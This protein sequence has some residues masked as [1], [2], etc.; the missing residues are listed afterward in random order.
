[1]H[2]I[3][4]FLVLIAAH[5]LCDYP[6]QGNFMSQFKHPDN[7]VIAGEKVWPWILGGH[8]AIHGAAVGL[9]TGSVVLGFAEF[10]AHCLTDYLKCRTYLTF[11][12][13]QAIHIACKAL[14][15]VAAA[16]GL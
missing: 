4:M 16:Y 8:G 10:V 9:V 1:M 7:G 15:V 12:Q 13:D 5:A 14:W 2:G 6:L 3:E 11:G